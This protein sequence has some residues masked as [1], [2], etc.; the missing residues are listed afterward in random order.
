[1]VYFVL[2][3]D[4]KSW[5]PFSELTQITETICGSP[6]FKS[7]V[8]FA[9]GSSMLE[10]Y[11]WNHK[12]HRCLNDICDFTGGSPMFEC[13]V[14]ISWTQKWFT[15]VWMTFLNS[16]KNHQR[17]SEFLGSRKHQRLSWF[18]WILL[19]HHPPPKVWSGLWGTGQSKL[20]G[21]QGLASEESERELGSKWNVWRVRK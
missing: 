19:N 8:C 21:H 1:M 9:Q 5:S 4:R 2:H 18:F 17:W 15:N 12:D 6:M 10:W 20:S 13:F 7:H 11:L 16:K 3:L 14:L